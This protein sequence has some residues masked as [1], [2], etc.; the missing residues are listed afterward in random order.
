MG[1]KHQVTYS[2][3]QQQM[4]TFWTLFIA[5][6]YLDQREHY[7]CS[8]KDLAETVAAKISTFKF[9][10]SQEINNYLP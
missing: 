6:F 3:F 9:L 8:L 1:V 2:H 5:C 7:Y 4:F 10:S